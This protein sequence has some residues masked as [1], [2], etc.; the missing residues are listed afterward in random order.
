MRV[1]AVVLNKTAVDF[2]QEKEGQC[3]RWTIHSENKCQNGGMERMKKLPAPL[4]TPAS[5]LSS[6]KEQDCLL[7]PRLPL[8]QSPTLTS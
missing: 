3:S 7:P 2:S 8:H 1:S 5:C 6:L 4:L